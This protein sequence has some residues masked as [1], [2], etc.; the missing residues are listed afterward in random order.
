M[1]IVSA[2]LMLGLLASAAN[3]DFV[4]PP[5]PPPPAPSHSG[6]SSGGGHGGGVANPAVGLVASVACMAVATEVMRYEKAHRSRRGC[7][8]LSAREAELVG[9]GCMN[10]L[11]ALG[12]TDEPCKPWG[13]K[14]YTIRHQPDWANKL[15]GWPQ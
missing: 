14:P 5:P 6:G 7:Y 10:P 9:M 8:G 11:G 3:A 2:A 13:G 15:S 4:A 1:R 12:Y